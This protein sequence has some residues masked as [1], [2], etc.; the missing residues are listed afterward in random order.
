MR[1]P[2]ALEYQQG[3]GPNLLLGQPVP[4]FDYPYGKELEL[5]DCAISKP[6]LNL[7]IKPAK[8]SL[9]KLDIDSS[10]PLM[11]SLYPNRQ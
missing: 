6:F 9:T 4:V 10:T 3:W 8:I 2:R 1:L 11:F 7:I 5:C